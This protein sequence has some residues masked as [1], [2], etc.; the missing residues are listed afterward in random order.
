MIDQII[1]ALAT[2]GPQNIPQLAQSIGCNES[3]LFEPAAALIL[4]RDV[5]LEVDGS[6]WL[7]M[8]VAA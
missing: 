6:L 4:R 7:A 2:K 8:E 5:H 1:N 3:A